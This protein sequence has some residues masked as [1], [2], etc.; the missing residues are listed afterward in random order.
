MGKKVFWDSKRQEYTIQ[1]TSLP[2][3]RLV[4]PPQAITALPRRCH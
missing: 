1:S 4:V 2:S 3:Q